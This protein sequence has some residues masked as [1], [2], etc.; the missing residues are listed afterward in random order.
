M[1]SILREQDAHGN[2]PAHAVFEESLEAVMSRVL[3][4]IQAGYTSERMIKVVGR[5]GEFDVFPFKGADLRNNTDVSVKKQSSL[6]DSRVAREARIM[7]R[8]Q[9]SLYGDPT[10]P[11]VRRHVMNMLD[12]AV[13]K[14]I[15]SDTK[16]DEAYARWE[17]TLIDQGDTTYLVNHY[18]NHSI[19]IKEHDHHRK[20]M[21][22]QKRK[23]ED[24]TGFKILDMAHETHRA[25]HQ[26][27]IDQQRREMLAA[28]AQ[29]QGGGKK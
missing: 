8:F 5:E 21:E 19:H 13:V 9:A 25:A 29:L 22:Y 27:Y 11:E 20:S 12:D 17:N 3:K 28:Q 23:L 6:P 15:Y 4:R 14:D 10:D 24:P 1:V 2:I 18:D 26:E 16:L 7:E